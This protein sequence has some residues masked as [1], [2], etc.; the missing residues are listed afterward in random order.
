MANE[1]L[2]LSWEAPLSG[3]QVAKFEIPPKL[4]GFKMWLDCPKGV[5]STL[6]TRQ[7]LEELVPLMI[8]GCRKAA[9]IINMPVGYSYVLGNQFRCHEVSSTGRVRDITPQFFDIDCAI[10]VGP[11]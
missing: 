6:T 11:L 1:T 7:R 10:K 4:N 5:S 8:Q 9:G 2:P 3:G